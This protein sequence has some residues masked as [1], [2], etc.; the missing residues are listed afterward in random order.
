MQLL[1]HIF[2]GPGNGHRVGARFLEDEQADRF[3]SGVARDR[4][5]LREAI[6]YPRHV[7]QTN[8]PVAFAGGAATDR[9]TGDH[10]V[11]D[12]FDSL[13]FAQGAQRVAIPAL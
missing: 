3:L 4:L 13:E 6:D 7:A 12:L 9:L 2:H 5:P 1:E 8:H 10:H 11:R